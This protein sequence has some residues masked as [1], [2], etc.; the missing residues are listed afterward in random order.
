[1]E[2]RAAQESGSAEATPWRLL[3]LLTAMTAIGPVTL[4]I[5]VPAL[6]RLATVLEADIGTVQLTLSLFLL[7]LAGAQLVL[8][9]LSDRFG[10]RP[11]VLA[12]LVLAT[13]ASF[14]AIVAP[15]AG[16]LVAARVAQALGAATGIV[17]G[18]AIIRD[19]YSRDRAAAMLGL[20]TTAMVLGPMLA[21]AIGGVL[22]T[23]FG[24]RAIFVFI[25]VLT[26]MVL[27][28]AV[29]D[30][31]ETRP[32]RPPGPS[33]LWRDCRALAGSAPFLGY[34]LAIT[35]GTIPFFAFIGGGPHVVVSIMSRSSAEYGFWFMVTSAGYMSGNFI[36]SRIS[37]RIGAPRMVMAGLLLEAAGGCVMVA[38][39]F[40]I[41]HGGPAVIFLP[42]ILVS[43]GNG[44]MM[45]NAMAGAVSVRPDAAGT[46]SG[47]VGFTQWAVGALAAQLVTLALVHATTPLPMALIIC[48]SVIV[49]AAVFPALVRR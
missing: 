46:A 3:T 41:P 42:Q 9:A 22:D 6:P 16:W 47:I 1:M 34:V 48:L 8:G 5:L 17:V 18:R 27:L 14:A 7:S 20:V 4:N 35:L 13:L 11:V 44:I 25:A 24:W 10:R 2:A 33:T 39:T 49:A 31:P 23:A 37:Q 15:S 45:P 19:L 12:G 38:V 40:F 32:E 30:L 28:W 26:L 43:V 36:A 29:W 21:P